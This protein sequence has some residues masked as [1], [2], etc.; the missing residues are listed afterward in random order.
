ME[1]RLLGGVQFNH[2]CPV[3]LGDNLGK[4]RVNGKRGVMGIMGRMGVK[5]GAG[6]ADRAMFDE[7]VGADQAKDGREQKYR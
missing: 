4:G 6:L 5:S 1:D 3:R 2:V 7:A